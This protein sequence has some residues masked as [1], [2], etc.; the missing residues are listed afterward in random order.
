MQHA[1]AHRLY[2]THVLEDFVCDVHFPNFDKTIFK[3]TRYV[4][5]YCFCEKLDQYNC[6]SILS[7]VQI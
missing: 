3:E 7:L 2:V 5:S 1:G 6:G 4:G